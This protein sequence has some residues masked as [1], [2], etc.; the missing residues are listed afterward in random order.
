MSADTFYCNVQVR[1]AS[2]YVDP[3]PAE[4]CEEEVENEG[5]LCPKHDGCSG[6]SSRYCE[7][8]AE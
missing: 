3:E 7:D 6:C 5:D 8:C 1:A 4:Y 2:W